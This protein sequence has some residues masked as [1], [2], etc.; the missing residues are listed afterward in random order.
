MYRR[1]EQIPDDLGTAVNVVAM[2]FGNLGETS[3]TGVAFTR[4]PSTGA[5]GTY[6]DYLQNARGEDVV[7]GSRNTI[8]LDQLEE[9][10]KVSY[11][12]LMR[13]ATQ[14]ERH[15]LDLCDIEFTIER[16]KLWLLQTRV[17]KRTPEAAF[18]IA[19]TFV[20]EG[21]IDRDTALSRVTG[22]QLSQLM[23]PRFD[24]LKQ[25]PPLTRG[26]G[27][28]PGAATGR[29]AFTSARAEELARSGQDVIPVRR[30]TNPDDLQGMIAAVGI[31]TSRGGKTSHAAVVARG[32]GRTCVC[33]AEQLVVSEDSATAGEVVLREGD[34]ISID[35]TTGEVF[36]GALPVVDSPLVRYLDGEIAPRRGR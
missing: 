27:A 28:S 7:S 12:E 33:G 18:R 4:D 19:N 29:V 22:G 13:V 24:D 32:M 6:G 35:G 3:G 34:V 23:F 14:L 2:V 5:A 21:L 20:H 9:L 25:A 11:D 10:D 16:G 36:L 26:I 15:Y 31:L 30:E 17:G 1:Q 8:P